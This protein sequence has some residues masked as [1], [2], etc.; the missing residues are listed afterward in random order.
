MKDVVGI[1]ST[2]NG[3]HMSLSKPILEAQKIQS[4][5][6]SENFMFEY[7]YDKNHCY[8][9]SNSRH[10]TKITKL[11]WNV[12]FISNIHLIYKLHIEY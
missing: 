4:F 9:R 7:L 3:K 12:R 11:N 2:H 10:E 1:Y 8:V 6:T 5:I